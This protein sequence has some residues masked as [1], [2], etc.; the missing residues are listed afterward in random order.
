MSLYQPA[1]C[2]LRRGI[3]PGNVMSEVRRS[4]SNAG[5]GAQNVILATWRD[6]CLG[7]FKQ[8]SSSQI[9]R[10]HRLLEILSTMSEQYNLSS[11]RAE[12]IANS[13]LCARSRRE[14]SLIYPELTSTDHAR[15]SQ[16]L[17]A[18]HGHA[19]LQSALGSYL[20]E[21]NRESRLS[22]LESLLGN[23]KNVVDHFEVQ[24]NQAS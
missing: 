11:D 22:D 5:P 15:L 23:L 24:D 12:E 14:R 19:G 18:F 21:S 6:H 10:L 7:H 13:Y 1:A 8:I 9:V 17:S 3:L 4:K 20:R 16:A 2:S